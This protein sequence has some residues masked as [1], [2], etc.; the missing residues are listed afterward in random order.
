MAFGETPRSNQR[1]LR[2]RRHPPSRHDNGT[3]AGAFGSR[4]S[5]RTTRPALR[6]HGSQGHGAAEIIGCGWKMLHCL[7]SPSATPACKKGMCFLC[8]RP[9]R[10]R[11]PASR[12]T[13]LSASMIDYDGRCSAS[14][15]DHQ[16]RQ[17]PLIWRC[18][19]R[20]RAGAGMLDRVAAVA[21]FME[22]ADRGHRISARGR[23]FR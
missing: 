3:A 7:Q 21:F 22:A 15:Q 8:P 9:S 11:E 4:I 14:G 16:E 2:P 23:L 19:L 17:T 20:F 10:H 1:K 5:F 12:I 13:I 18:N 6:V